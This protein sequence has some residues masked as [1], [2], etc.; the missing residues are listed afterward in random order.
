MD[1]IV[2]FEP[3]VS[4]VRSTGVANGGQTDPTLKIGKGRKT[5]GRERREKGKGKEEKKEEREGKREGKEKD[6]RKKGKKKEKGKE[7]KRANG[8][9]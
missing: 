2:G 3:F 1:E 9:E 4:G 8:G 7:R 6:K 5:S